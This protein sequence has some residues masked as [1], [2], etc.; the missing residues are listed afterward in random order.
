MVMYRFSND[1]VKS[2]WKGRD[3]FR[4]AETYQKAIAIVQALAER[5]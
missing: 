5:A 3:D 4:G 1:N 2:K